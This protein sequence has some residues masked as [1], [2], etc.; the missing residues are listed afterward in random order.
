MAGRVVL[1]LDMDAFYAAVEIREDAS[2]AGKPLIIGHDGKRGVVATCSYEARVDGVRS[3]MPSVTAARLCPNAVWLPPRMELYVEVSR[4]IRRIMDAEAPVVEPLSIDEAFLDL[5][6]W[7]ADLEAGRLVA[8]RLKD[9]IKREQRL[10]ASVGVAPNKFLAKLASDLEKPDGLVV[11]PLEDVPKRLWPLPVGRLW[12]VGPK[13]AERFERAG[14]YTVGDVAK[15]SI[16]ALASLVGD[17][18][19]RHVAA[20]AQGE[21]DRRVHADPES[22]SISEE[23]TYSED[24]RD[25][26]DIDRA[27]LARS[28]GVARSLRSSGL[29]GRTVNL[30]IRT[31][32]FTTWTRATTLSAPTDLAEPI[33]EAARAM[34]AEKID[35]AGHGV[36]LIGV[37]M[38]GLVT[39]SSVPTHLF[40]DPATDRARKMAEAQDA[41]REKL[42]ERAV[43]RAT[44][45]KKRAD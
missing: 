41:V 36:R 21:D 37:G 34:F 4:A 18:L 39:A 38:S 27:L 31:G 45:L 8:R 6:G 22:K 33:V 17:G 3:A 23:R 13:S 24:L 16:P 25:P 29:K 40:S 5:T 32:D 1:H 35:L 9:R 14:I 11:F 19:A 12:G 26:R 44:L 20:L 15:I 28:E 43:T 2:L 7:A 42:G 30:K 10:T